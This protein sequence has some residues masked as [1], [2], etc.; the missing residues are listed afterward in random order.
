MRDRHI[1]DPSVEITEIQLKPCIHHLKLMPHITNQI[2]INHQLLKMC[3]PEP[4]LEKGTEH[5]PV[6]PTIRVTD[7]VLPIWYS[8]CWLTELDTLTLTPHMS[9]DLYCPDYITEPNLPFRECLTSLLIKAW[10]L[11]WH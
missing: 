9:V 3:Q 2:S 8:R 6:S 1:I 4:I 10:Q 7:R 5:V 11:A